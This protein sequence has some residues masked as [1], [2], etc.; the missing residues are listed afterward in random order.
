MARDLL[1]RDVSKDDLSWIAEAR[2]T[3]TQNEFLKGILKNAR[4]E[5]FQPSLFDRVTPPKIIHG[6]MP[7]KFIDLFAG[8]GGFRSAMT[9]LGGECV[10][11][12]EWD[13]YAAKTY[14]AW[15]GDDEISTGDIWNVDVKK[16]IPDHDIL[17]AGFP[18]QPFSLAGVSKKKSLGRSHGFDDE[19]QGNLFFAIMK[20]VNAKRPPILILENVK[21]LRSHDKRNTWKVIQE[22][23]EGSGYE[24]FS[25]VIDAQSWVPQHRERIFIVCFDKK[26]FGPKDQID[27]SFPKTPDTPAPKLGSILH[28]SPPDKKYMLSD[29]LWAYLQ[30]YAEKHR[31]KGNGFGYS[32]FG[33]NDVARTLSARYHKDGSEILIKQARWRNPRRLTPSEA[34]QLMGFSSRYSELFGHENGFSQVV[35]DTQ[36]YRQFGNS[37]VPQVVE[38]VGEEVVRTMAEVFLRS[39]NGCLIKGRSIAA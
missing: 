23:I 15:Y 39:N 30:A 8:I 7:F 34:M 5:A 28:K 6:Q 31:A 17:C 24:V 33:K 36:A 10:F 27:F 37:V 18:C 9:A 20:I 32:R 16:E 12:S 11:T 14:Q 19:K 25:D 22:T 3:E 26:I 2:Q 29:K 21:N 13:K 38:A 4:T 1:I 35:S